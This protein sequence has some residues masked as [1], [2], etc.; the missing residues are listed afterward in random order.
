MNRDFRFPKSERL[1]SRTLIRQLFSPQGK[2]LAAYPL[3]VVW[4]PLEAG[5]EA[6]VQMMVSVSKRKLRH[7]VDRNRAK[8]LVRE[9]Y[10]LNKHLLLDPLGN[11][12]LA[13]VFLWLPSE[14]RPFAEVEAKMCNLLLRV[15]EQVVG[16]PLQSS[17][18]SAKSPAS[19]ADPPVS[20][21]E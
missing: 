10:R 15:A 21:A 5:R 14:P 16:L 1:C 7:A 20:A 18:S 12:C 11:Q 9:A 19:P 8:R 6:R 4:M 13:V 2:S 17:V 3:R